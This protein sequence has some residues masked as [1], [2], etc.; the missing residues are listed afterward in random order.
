MDDDFEI[1]VTD[2]NTGETA[3]H[4]LADNPPDDP[5]SDDDELPQCEPLQS[6]PPTS[7]SARR[8]RGTRAAI[9]SGFLAL[10]VILVILINPTAKSSLYT[11]FRFPTPVPS[12]TPL[13]G[14]DLVYLM[15]GAPWGT[16]T[17]DGKQPDYSRLGM[18]MAW[19]KLTHGRHTLDVTQPPFRTVH[20]TVSYPAATSDNCP[21]ITPSNDPNDPNWT[22]F[23]GPADG[24]SLPPGSRFVDLGARFSL[25]PKDAQDALVAAVNAQVNVSGTPL[26]LQPGDH[27]LRDDGTA[28]VAMT[29][30]Q[31][32]F[33]PTLLTP[34]N[35][36]TSDDPSCVSFCDI[37]G[38]SLDGG[39]TWNM[40]V[41]EVGSWHV[42]TLGGQT[43][44]ESAPMFVSNPI[45]QGLPPTMQFTIS[46]L[47]T[48]TWQVSLQNGYGSSWNPVCQ[49]AQMMLSNS[50]GANQSNFQS[51]NTQPGRTPEE[52]C[53]MSVQFGDQ[54]Q[55]QNQSDP[56]YV[57]YRLGSL[58][59]VN[60]AAH[61]L[62]P[63]LPLASANERAQAQRLLA[64]VN[65]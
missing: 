18:A 5:L 6:G 8:R 42:A 9:V 32:T 48:G 57:L 37:T 21:L 1:E 17:V 25:L 49:A 63:D 28:A 11:V 24:Q 22:P 59:A 13:P 50:M 35:T 20:C 14:G 4:P 46:V 2:L 33:I 43:L 64:G 44:T 12:P 10:A 23:S 62:F 45:Y 16:V 40:M 38:A 41:A 56:A 55:N 51:W 31:A 54:N 52:G 36:V 27:Y 39:G 7:S 15:R 60:D 61:R 29:T 34:A 65:G 58:L 47:W 53:A 3:R 19:V 26:T 30:L